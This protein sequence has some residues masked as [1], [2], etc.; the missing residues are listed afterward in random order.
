MPA[1]KIHRKIGSIKPLLAV[2]RAAG[3]DEYQGLERRAPITMCGENNIPVKPAIRSHM[4]QV[5]R[6]SLNVFRAS[7]VAAVIVKVDIST[8]VEIREAWGEGLDE[9][10]VVVCILKVVN[11]GAIRA[12]ENENWIGIDCEHKRG[13]SRCTAHSSVAVGRC[14]CGKTAA[15]KTIMKYVTARLGF[16]IVKS[17]GKHGC[18]AIWV[19]NRDVHCPGSTRRRYGLDLGRT[20]YGH[21]WRRSSPERHKRSGLKVLACDRHCSSSSSRAR[22]RRNTGHRQRTNVKCEAA[23]QRARLSVGVADGDVYQASNVCGHYSL[24]LCRTADGHR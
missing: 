12:R 10:S 14:P 8:Q 5:I 7:E 18:Q 13:P 20:A 6:L 3:V 16:G 2:A 15:L 23:A 17:T 21:G 9:S 1:V 11:P 19:L 22:I 4:F 24:N